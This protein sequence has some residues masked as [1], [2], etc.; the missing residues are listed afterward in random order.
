MDSVE[1]C[2]GLFALQRKQLAKEKKA[3]ESNIR[4]HWD[5]GDLAER[6]IARMCVSGENHID[7]GH[8]SN[9]LI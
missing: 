1:G 8:D 7:Q 6:N 5:C 3:R 4:A 9:F 2:V